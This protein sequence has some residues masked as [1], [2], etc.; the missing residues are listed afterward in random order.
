MRTVAALWAMALAGAVAAEEPGS[1]WAEAARAYNLDPVALYAIA[2]QE[3]RTLRPDGTA[4]PWPWTLRSSRGG[5]QRFETLPEARAA[6]EALVADGVRNVDIGLMQVNLG[7]HGFRVETPAELLDPYRN[8]LVGA[9]I[10]HDALQAHDGDLALA[11]GAYHHGART[12]RGRRYSE[13]VR[14]RMRQLR[15]LPGMARALSGAGR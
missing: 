7:V 3:S 2:L 5:P 10:L 13:D 6:L 1:V 15:A 8:V 11:L 4:R 12:E 9:A 14:R